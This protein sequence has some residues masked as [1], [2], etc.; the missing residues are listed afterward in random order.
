MSSYAHLSPY[1]LHP[2]KFARKFATSERCALIYARLTRDK[3]ELTALTQHASHLPS[4]KAFVSELDAIFETQLQISKQIK[5]VLADR[6]AMENR[7]TE[8]LVALC[9]KT[10]GDVNPDAVVTEVTV[11]LERIALSLISVLEYKHDVEC[12]KIQGV[13]AKYERI[14][15]KELVYTNTNLIPDLMNLFLSY[16]FGLV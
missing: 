6:R 14:F 15:V 4:F 2:Q 7:Y 11:Y 5:E 12:D 1:N 16:L 3:E 9:E 13:Y 10:D 8:E